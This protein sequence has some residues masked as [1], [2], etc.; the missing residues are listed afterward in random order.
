MRQF[1]IPSK[2]GQE[3][4]IQYILKT[5]SIIPNKEKQWYEPPCATTL[6]EKIQP[7]LINL[8]PVMFRTLQNTKF[9]DDNV[10]KA[11]RCTVAS[12]VAPSTDGISGAERF[13]HI[14]NKMKKVG[15]GVNSTA[16][17]AG[18]QEKGRNL[19]STDINLDDKKISRNGHFVDLDDEGLVI[20]KFSKSVEEGGNEDIYR[21]MLIG[22]IL[23]ELRKDIPN[24]AQTY[25]LVG[26]DKVFNDSFFCSNSGN[27]SVLIM[28]K[29][30]GKTFGDWLKN[31]EDS[32]DI[33][34]QLYSIM[35]QILQAIWFS[36]E[37]YQF[38]HNDLHADNIL[39][40]TLQT[41]F[42]IP[43]F[44]EEG[45]PIF[46]STTVIPT[47]IDY[48]YSRLIIKVHKNILDELMIAYYPTDLNDGFVNVAIGTRGFDSYRSE[49][50]NFRS[51]YGPQQNSP[52][53]DIFRIVSYCYKYVWEKPK[54]KVVLDLVLKDFPPEYKITQ[55]NYDAWAER[56]FS[57]SQNETEV[58]T[59]SGVN[60]NK[61]IKQFYTAFSTIY[62][63]QIILVNNASLMKISK[64][65]PIMACSLSI[66]EKIERNPIL[67]MNMNH[68]NI[69]CE[70]SLHGVL[71][72]LDVIHTATEGKEM[73]DLILY[74]D[75]I[76]MHKD[77][78]LKTMSPQDRSILFNLIQLAEKQVKLFI[79]PSMLTIEK[80]KNE[81]KSI[82]EVSVLNGVKIKNEMSSEREAYLMTVL[83]EAYKNRNIA[84]Q[85][86]NVLWNL[87]TKGV[88]LEA[89][90]E[91]EYINLM[92]TVKA[93][94]HKIKDAA[95]D[96][97]YYT[98]DEKIKERA[99]RLIF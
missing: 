43:Y 59:F 98:K 15:E 71:K 12:I 76:M 34:I 25:G 13:F 22:Q 28:E 27:T 23:N 99:Q 63:T 14:F 95:S 32:T 81:Y 45:S 85:N 46:L 11:L 37:K 16:M 47:V 55:A 50:G 74:Y 17:S 49:T 39:V 91:T 1:I 31:A 8:N 73:E 18:I 38:S 5:N 88:I 92:E 42:Y 30:V 82:G 36:Y 51:S 90:R 53:F 20:G 4:L 56:Y 96:I 84:A 2:K 69:G 93:I 24:F 26:C 67:S 6:E 87:T 89:G 44:Y 86:L 10:Q 21:E 19:P 7:E 54:L 78:S 65:I 70:A 41:P 60:I 75:Y 35:F 77:V 40:R 97:A 79:N 72:K 66:M 57:L 58:L 29:I 9:Y 62:P 52:L 48:G 61:I 64:E 33:Q 3:L 83:E 80:I 68:L 94:S